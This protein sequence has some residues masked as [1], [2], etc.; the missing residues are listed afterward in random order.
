MNSWGIGPQFEEFCK[1]KQTKSTISLN[2]Y[3]V[4]S[5]FWSFLFSINSKI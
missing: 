3:G 1:N 2:L 5:T 4:H